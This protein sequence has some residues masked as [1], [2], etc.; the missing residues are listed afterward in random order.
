MSLKDA[1]ASVRALRADLKQG[2]KSVEL[3]QGKR[4]RPKKGK[5]DKKKKV[6]KGEKAKKGCARGS[7]PSLSSSP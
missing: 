4:P 1:R 5:R 3:K 2:N 6:S 7:G